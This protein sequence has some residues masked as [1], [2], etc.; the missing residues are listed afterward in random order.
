MSDVLY[1]DAMNSRGVYA[2]LRRLGFRKSPTGGVIWYLHQRFFGIPVRLIAW[3]YVYE[4]GKYVRITNEM[5]R[6]HRIFYPSELEAIDHIE[7]R[8]GGE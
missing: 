7:I 8:K 4:D 2:D 1:L 6:E 5:T 3:A